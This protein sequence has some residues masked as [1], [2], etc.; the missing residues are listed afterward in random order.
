MTGIVAKPTA[1]SLAIP[2]VSTAFVFKIGQEFEHTGKITS[3]FSIDQ[4][5]LLRPL[6][7]I[8]SLGATIVCVVIIRKRFQPA[9]PA[10]LITRTLPNRLHHLLTLML[11]AQSRVSN[12]PL[13]LCLDL[14]RSC[15]QKILQPATRS[16]SPNRGQLDRPSDATATSSIHI[17]ITI[18]A[19]SHTSFSFLGGSNS[20]STIDL[21]NA[22]N[23][24]SNYSIL[25]VAVLL[26]SAN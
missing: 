17:A 15:L 10:S 21:S 26:F 3:A 6:L 8:T 18:L 25:T 22:F 9:V 12:L 1:I 16:P 13:F 5:V 2:L 7:G 4:I 20:I 19:F 11:M 23:G 24:I 14:Q